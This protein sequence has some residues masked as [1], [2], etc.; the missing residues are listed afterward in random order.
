MV[1]WQRQ[2]DHQHHYCLADIQ[3]TLIVI[4]I[5]IL[6]I[7]NIHHHHHYPTDLDT[8]HSQI[9]FGFSKGDDN[10]GGVKRKELDDFCK[11]LGKQM[12]LV[13]YRQGGWKSIL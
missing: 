1:P 3:Y 5:I 12:N 8:D 10:Y 7:Y 13:L 2:G 9:N 6:Q 4:I 11:S